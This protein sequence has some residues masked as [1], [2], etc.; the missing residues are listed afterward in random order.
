MNEL[1]EQNAKWDRKVQ[2]VQV[3]DTQ[4]HTVEL[5]LLMGARSA[6]QAFD[7]RCDIREAMIRFMRE[8]YP[9][10]LPRTRVEM[11][12]SSIST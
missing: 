4:T 7:L 9:E 1:L 5:R 6:P 3:T 12:P 2:A 11:Q 10:S 8:A